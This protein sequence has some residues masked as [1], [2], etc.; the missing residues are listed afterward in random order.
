MNDFIYCEQGKLCQI[1]PQL[2]VLP[3]DNNKSNPTAGRQG[4]H[5]RGVREPGQNFYPTANSPS[6]ILSPTTP[7]LVDGI[8]KWCSLGVPH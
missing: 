3:F 7:K 6:T 8:G 2:I 1:L 4:T 5:T